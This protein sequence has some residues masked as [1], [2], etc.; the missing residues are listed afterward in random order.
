MKNSIKLW[1]LVLAIVT[2]KLMTGCYKDKTVPL[3]TGTEVTKTVSLS[4]DITPIFNTNCSISGCHNSGGIKP[5]LTSDRVYNSL[6]NDN[7]IDLNTPEKS[8][9][10][11][12]LTGKGSVPMPIGAANNPSNINQLILAWIKQGAQN[13]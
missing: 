10:Y 2:I 12:W 11:L 9:I 1:A 6:I 5:V 4:K 3:N 8:D 13:N 7:Y